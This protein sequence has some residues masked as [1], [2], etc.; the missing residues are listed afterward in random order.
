[1]QAAPGFH[2]LYLLLC[3]GGTAV[4]MLLEESW[5]LLPIL[6]STTPSRWQV[7]DGHPVLSGG[8]GLHLPETDVRRMADGLALRS[9]A[10][11]LLG[12]G[13][14]LLASDIAFASRNAT[15]LNGN[16]TSADSNLTF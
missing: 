14:H 4:A 16:L 2:L 12:N 8:V 9:R 15:F 13:G 7:P 11:R 5:G 3:L 6:R 10:L 1:M